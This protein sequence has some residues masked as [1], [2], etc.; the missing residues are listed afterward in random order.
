M[1]EKHSKSKLKRNKSSVKDLQPAISSLKRSHTA[2]VNTGTTAETGRSVWWSSE[3]LPPEQ[4]LWATVLQ[5]ALPYLET[6]HLVP[7]LPHPSAAK[8]T[9]LKFNEQQWCDL[10][11][12][13]APFP[14]PSPPSPRTSRGPDPVSPGSSQQELWVNTKSGPDPPARPPASHSRRSH[15]GETAPLQDLTKRAR[16]SLHS[17]EGPPSLAGPS[18]VGG[19]KGRAGGGQEEE[20]G[21]VN[22]RLLTDQVLKSDRRVSLQREDEEEEEEE[23]HTSVRGDE[24]AAAGGGGR[25]GGLQS[26]PM[27]L[28]VFPVGFTQTDCDGHLAQCLSEVNVDMTW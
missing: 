13:V 27:C 20:T 6:R 24:G 28:M 8:P 18:G 10:S 2:S 12:E 19:H 25:G 9:A 17:W 3:Q 14:E 26:C 1:A 22:S 23:V 5:S 11:E 16:P 15:D 4:S 21:P 7:D